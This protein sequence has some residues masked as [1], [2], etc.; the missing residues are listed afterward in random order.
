MQKSDF[1]MIDAKDSELVGINHG[2]CPL[3]LKECKALT[4]FD[5]ELQEF[6]D[7]FGKTCN[8]CME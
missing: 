6:S 5:Q 1:A 3:G 2:E 8:E 7:K 4:S